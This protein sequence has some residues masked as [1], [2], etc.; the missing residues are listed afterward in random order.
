MDTMDNHPIPCKMVYRMVTAWAR[1]SMAPTLT[2]T[3][4]KSDHLP[5]KL[6]AVVLKKLP[7]GCHADGGNLYL[8]VR[9]TSR[10]WVF[11]YTSP[12]DAKR[13]NM[14]LG[15]LDAVPLTR[16]R[17]LARE[18]RGMVKDRLNPVDPMQMLA[19]AKAARLSSQAKQK[20]FKECAE[21]YLE[22]HRSGWANRN[23]HSSGRTRSR[24]TLTRSSAVYQ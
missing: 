12:T 19:D 7:D 3:K 5:G 4:T 21:L 1:I 8:L 10:S 17:E 6:A 9:G 18:Y 2:T 20:T 15:S 11:R 16:A 13:R 22:L 24:R 23:M 14:G